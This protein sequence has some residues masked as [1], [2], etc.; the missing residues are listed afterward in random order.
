MVFAIKF[1]IPRTSLCLVDVSLSPSLWKSRPEKL[2]RWVES[3]P[4]PHKPCLL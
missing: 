2:V 4:G 1:V 3:R